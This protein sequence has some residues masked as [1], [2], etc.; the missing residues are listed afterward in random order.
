[1]RRARTRSGISQLAGRK[2]FR[3]MR[4]IDEVGAWSVIGRVDRRMDHPPHQVLAEDV[5][6]DRRQRLAGAQE[7]LVGGAELAVR[8]RVAFMAANDID[9]PVVQQREQRRELRHDGVIVVARIGDQRLG[10]G[11]ANACD[12]AVDPRHVLG[13]GPRDVAERAAG[14]P[15]RSPSSAFARAAA[16]CGGRHSAHRARRCA[17]IRQ[18]RCRTGSPAEAACGARSR[19]R[20]RDRPRPKAGSPS[21]RDRAQRTAADRC[22]RRE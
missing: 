14:S 18:D 17:A 16:W 20:R 22:S 12:A 15:A 6:I 3:R 2:A 7:A 21:A 9:Q 11:D 13:R 8:P 1:M 4:A 19:S 5:V 10:E